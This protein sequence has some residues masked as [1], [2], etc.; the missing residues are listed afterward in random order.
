MLGKLM[1]YEFKACGRIF[2][3]LYLGI[4]VLSIINGINFGVNFK[5]R[6][7][8]FTM[9]P[10]AN[11]TQSILML[12]LVALFVALL[13]ITIVLTIQRFKKNLLDDEGY[14]MFTLPVKSSS[15][16]L[17]KFLAA[18]IYGI[19]STIV[20]LMSI[21]IMGIIIGIIGGDVN[22]VEIFNIFS[23]RDLF[24]EQGEVLFYMTLS[25]LINYSIFILTIYLSLS[26]G[27]LPQLSKH[28]VVAGVVLFFVINLIIDNV[29]NF[30]I[31]NS[32]DRVAEKEIANNFIVSNFSNISLDLLL[33]IVIGF[34][35]FLLT[36][37]ILNKK[38]NLE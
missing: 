30:V 11:N 13:V 27:Q 36:N 37:W 31:N 8:G 15:L 26:I 38:L 33:S 1:K 23:L 10:T 34:I 4:L 12:V 29:Q 24:L 3:P 14:L 28:R 9:N 5:N 17:S 25:L 2:F 20:A 32:L 19:I 22:L 16:I 21:I 35:L 7:D 18:L 6:I